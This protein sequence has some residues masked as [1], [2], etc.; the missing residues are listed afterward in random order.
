MHSQLIPTESEAIVAS[1]PVTPFRECIESIQ[2]FTSALTTNQEIG[3]FFA[4]CPNSSDPLPRGLEFGSDNARLSFDFFQNRLVTVFNGD[5]KEVKL[6]CALRISCEL[7]EVFMKIMAAQAR[8]NQALLEGQ[9]TRSLQ[10]RDQ[11]DSKI[12]VDGKELVAFRP[13]IGR[14]VLSTSRGQSSIPIAM[15]RNCGHLFNPDF[16]KEIGPLIGFKG[17][18]K[19]LLIAVHKIYLGRCL[20]GLINSKEESHQVWYQ[21]ELARIV[22]LIQMPGHEFYS[23][24]KV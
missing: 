16:A 19:S 1:I 10:F 23:E 17:N 5:V 12:I 15:I 24:P 9:L 3:R 20:L 21:R 18:V 8:E 13:S 7:S 4:N 14:V 6:S 2:C 11:A 22:T